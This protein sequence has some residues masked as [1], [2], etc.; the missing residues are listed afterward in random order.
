MRKRHSI[1]GIQKIEYEKKYRRK[2][3]FTR[4]RFGSEAGVGIFESGAI[5]PIPGYPGS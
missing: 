4:I 2:Y 3:V 1:P 5:V